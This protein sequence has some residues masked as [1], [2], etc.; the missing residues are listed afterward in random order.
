MINPFV[1]QAQGKIDEVKFEMSLTNNN[2]FVPVK[3]VERKIYWK[4]D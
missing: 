2:E 3:S 1:C 4:F